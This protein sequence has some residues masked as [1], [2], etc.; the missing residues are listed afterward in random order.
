MGIKA[1]TTA[2]V[3]TIEL[4]ERQACDVFCLLHGAF[5]PLT[6]FMDETTYKSVVSGMRLP[7]KQL[8]GMPVTFDV[9]DV[10][11]LKEGDKLLLRWAGKDVAVLEAS[12]IFKP[13]KV[14]EAKECYGTS[15]LEHPTVHSLIAE[16]GQY[17]VGGRVHGIS[18]PEFKY[19]VRVGQ[20]ELVQSVQRAGVVCVES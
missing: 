19:P 16:Q 2:S 15:S 18:S 17:Y 1:L 9:H 5:S 3:R 13:N 11:G 7:E 6:G 4:N 12:S 8:F 14:V 20:N 10:S